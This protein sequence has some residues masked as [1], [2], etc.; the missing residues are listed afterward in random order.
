MGAESS[1]LRLSREVAG[2]QEAL[3]DSCLPPL[4]HRVGNEVPTPGKP[5]KLPRAQARAGCRARW[6]GSTSRP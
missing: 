4:G 1:V 5:S 6:A 3:G 2:T